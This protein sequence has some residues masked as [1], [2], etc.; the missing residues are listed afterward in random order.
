MR[1]RE[2]PPGARVMRQIWR[3][4]GFLHWPVARR[5]DRAPAAARPRGRH[6]R[7][8]RVRRRRAVHDPADAH[9][10]LLGAADG[11]GVPR[12]QRAD[13]RPPRRPRSRRLVLQPR[14]RQPAGGRGR[15]R[16]R[17]GCRTFTPHRCSRGGRAARRRRLPLAP[18]AG[19]GR[20]RAPA[21]SRRA[22]SRPPRPDRSSSSSPSAT[23][24]IAWTGR[25]LRT[26]R[27]HHAPYPLQAAAAADVDQTLTDAARLAP[28]AC[29]G[30]PPLV[31]YAREVDVAIFGPPRPS[32]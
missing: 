5:R 3:H 23:C 20:V 13:V 25:A 32:P 4:L 27:V 15:A 16:S 10:P 29:A 31:H 24:C 28:G 9:R 7:R 22:R 12:A 30:P 17:T 21:T 6:L 8:R 1:A 2:R 19:G 14:R 26:A 11:A 18:R